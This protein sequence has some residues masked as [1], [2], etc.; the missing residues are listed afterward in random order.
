MGTCAGKD[1]GRRRLGSILAARTGVWS[2]NDPICEHGIWRSMAAHVLLSFLSQLISVL[3]SIRLDPAR[4]CAS[5]SVLLPERAIWQSHRA[6][7]LTFFSFP[8]RRSNWSSFC[9]MLLNKCRRSG[10]IQKRP[11]RQPQATRK[12]NGN[13]SATHDEFSI[14]CN[15]AY[16]VQR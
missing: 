4:L 15:H 16:S 8:L 2:E 13:C 10:F 3:R 12:L 7:M 9:A 1:G 14:E 5:R 11:S 6:L